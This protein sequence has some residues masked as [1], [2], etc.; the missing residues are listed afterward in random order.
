MSTNQYQSSSALQVGDL[1]RRARHRQHHRRRHH[2]LQCHPLHQDLLVEVAVG[3]RVVMLLARAVQMILI[4]GPVKTNVPE[5]VEECG[6][7]SKL[8][9]AY[10]FE[11]LKACC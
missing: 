10:H 4:A 11:Q 9:E 8:S 5:I 1:L 3:A 6:V 7:R 2:Q